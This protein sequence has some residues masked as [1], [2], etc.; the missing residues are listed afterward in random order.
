M[1]LR[2]WKPAA[3]ALLCAA[4]FVEPSR[5]AP[6]PSPWTPPR[7]GSI[8][9]PAPDS[10]ARAAALRRPWI[11]GVE[12][13]GQFL[14]DSV[15]LAR[16]EQRRIIVGGFVDAYFASYAEYRPRPDEAGLREFLTSMINKEV[17]GL[18]ALSINRPLG[19]EDRSVMREFTER[20]LSNTLYQRAVMDSVT[21]TE[22]ELKAVYAQHQ[23]AQHLRHILFATRP[24]AERVRRDLVAR[25]I[26]W[27]N[28]VQ[29][30]SQAPA[31]DKARDGDLGWHSRFGF[32]PGIVYEV[33]SLQ[34]GE[35]SPVLSDVKGYQLV[36]A[37][38]RKPTNPPAYQ[39]IRS[40]IMAEVRGRK[41][42]VRAER[43][44]ATMRAE[45]GMVYDTTNIEWASRQFTPSIAAGREGG[46]TTLELNAD[47]PDFA[48]GDTSRVLARHRTG[49]LT[50]GAFLGEY[51]ALSPLMR[52][53][54]SDFEGMRS[55]VDGIVL[56]PFMAQMAIRRGLDRDSMAVHQIE[57]RREE[58]LVQH[59]YDDSVTTRVM[60]KPEERH[61]YYKD[62]LPSFFTY[63][64]VT[65]AAFVR[66]SRPAADSLAARLRGGTKATDLL[67]A[68]SL[69]GRT[70]GSIQGRSG[71]D[72]GTPYYKLLFEE[73]RPGQVS[74]EGPDK[75]GSFA[76]IQLLTFDPGHQLTYE[77]SQGYIDES[78]Q[79]IKSEERLKALLARLKK[80]YSIE[81]HPELL[82]RVRM[83]DPTLI[84]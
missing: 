69:A 58:I 40:S 12:D 24:D 2:G 21:V 49:Q 31:E 77:Q 74:V 38:E 41:S 70:T 14:P 30:Y 64:R 17:L 80:R 26:G 67:R 76:V 81:S 33:F 84:N 59:L 61:K 72:H 71:N 10:A 19:F 35:I 57:A 56:E 50:L 39:D 52:P 68:D 62:N 23:I 28:A 63:P 44:R 66:T 83:V 42:E 46:Q 53:S 37:V 47:V 43:M 25:R 8:T 20:V 34:P 22:D 82:D 4:L 3:L 11:N 48:P 79:N 75:V 16:V 60:I 45:I 15:L 7:K 6:A 65:F 73:L 5:P 13:T 55:E 51:N 32:D 78:L 1:R 9:A 18:T 36:Q 29:K 54:V 27:K